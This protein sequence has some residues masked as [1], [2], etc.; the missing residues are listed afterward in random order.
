M[1][2]SVLFYF[3]LSFYIHLIVFII[4]YTTFFVV[5]SASHKVFWFH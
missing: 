1:E 4:A 2:V 5:Y 3:F